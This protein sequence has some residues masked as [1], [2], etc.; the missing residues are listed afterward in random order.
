M[1]RNT[2]LL[3]DTDESVSAK[4]LANRRAG[5]RAAICGC[6]IGPNRRCTLRLTPNT[7]VLGPATTEIE[8]RTPARI[9]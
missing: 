5:R 4:L 8:L 7:S 2:N 1:W 3:R 9:G 6:D